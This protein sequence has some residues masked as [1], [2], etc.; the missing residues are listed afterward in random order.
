[1]LTVGEGQT[2]VP[3]AAPVEPRS[4]CSPPMVTILSLC[5]ANSADPFL[6]APHCSLL[7]YEAEAREC[8]SKLVELSAKVFALRQVR[9]WCCARADTRR[10]TCCLQQSLSSLP[11]LQHSSS[12]KHC[13]VAVLSWHSVPP[14]S[15]FLF[16]SG[17][18]LL[19]PRRRRCYAILAAARCCFLCLQERDHL[20]TTA[21]GASKLRFKMQE[22]GEV[23]PGLVMLR[24]PEPTP[25]WWGL[26]MWCRW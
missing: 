21:E 23:R 6:S 26:P 22:L 16:A 1:M 10:C 17:G 9:S 5:L 19:E 8:S 7:R 2:H 11:V 15:L 25:W 24:E 20:A 14:L 18:C 4:S 3:A 12:C 13:S